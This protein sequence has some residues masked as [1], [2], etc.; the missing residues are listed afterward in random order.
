MEKQLELN[1]KACQ[2]IAY[3]GTLQ[4]D[5]QWGENALHSASIRIEYDA[6]LAGVKPARDGAGNSI[7]E[8]VEITLAQLE[9]NFPG[10]VAQ[11]T[12]IADFYNPYKNAQF[13]QA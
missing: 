4:E 5:R 2:V 9:T 6:E 1:A 11:M 13:T 10:I 12:A 3:L 7:P 8:K